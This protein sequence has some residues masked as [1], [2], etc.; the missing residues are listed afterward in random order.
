MSQ[1]E[2]GEWQGVLPTLVAA[3]AEARGWKIAV[4]R[5]S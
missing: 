5:L 2:L 3:L 1:E 4:P